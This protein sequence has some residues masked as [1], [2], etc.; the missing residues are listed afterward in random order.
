MT[1]LHRSYRLRAALPL[2]LWLTGCGGGSAPP[3]SDTA[4]SGPPARVS[5]E[6]APPAPDVLPPLPIE[7]FPAARPVE[8]VQAIYEFAARHPEVLRTVPC[9]CGCEG[10]GHKGNDDCFV[11]SRDAQGQVSW[12]AHGAT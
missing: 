7:A 9:F 5:S 3:P 10:A 11:R 4:A 8:V 6:N 1:S 12:E 2:V